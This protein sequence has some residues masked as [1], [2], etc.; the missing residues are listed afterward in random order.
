MQSPLFAV[1]VDDYRRGRPIPADIDTW[2]PDRAWQ[3]ERGRQWAA[4]APIGTL[5]RVLGRSMKGACCEGSE[6]ERES[7]YSFGGM[8]VNGAGKV[9]TRV[10]RALIAAAGCEISTS[11]VLAWVYPREERLHNQQRR[12]IRKVLEGLCE[13]VRLERRGRSFVVIWR[14][15]GAIERARPQHPPTGRLWHGWP[16]K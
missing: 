8:P 13:R 15:R 9:R 1:G 16:G 10:H 3:Y 12:A 11:D 2:H 5:I 4:L 6:A 14:A 7:A